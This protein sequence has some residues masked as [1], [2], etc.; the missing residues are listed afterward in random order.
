MEIHVSTQALGVSAERHTKPWKSRIP[1]WT[2]SIKPRSLLALPWVATGVLMAAVVALQVRIE[3]RQAPIRAQ[4]DRLRF[5]LPGEVLTPMLLGYRHVG[6][7]LLW[8]QIIQVLGD[9][10]VT[11]K[12]YEWLRH[13]LHVL[14]TLDPQ[15]VYAYDIGALALTELAGRVDWGNELLEKGIAANPTAWRLSFQLGFNQFFY[16]QDYLRAADSMARAARLPGRP[17]YVPELAARLYVQAQRPALA[18]QFLQ[19]M[20]EQ[21]NDLSLRA[22]LERRAKDVVI[23]RDIAMI[24]RAVEA[25]RARMAREPRALDELVEAGILASIPEEPFGGDYQLA[26]GRATSTTHPTRLSIHGRHSHASD[27]S[28]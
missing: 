25:F 10:A 13:A 28:R 18:L 11:Q 17:A 24:Q 22:G 5:L 21:T 2:R 19:M 14:T 1:S 27:T 16:Q 7:D 6:T 4:V 20:L 26:A 23:E 8:L 3:E 9:K 15:Y 12:D